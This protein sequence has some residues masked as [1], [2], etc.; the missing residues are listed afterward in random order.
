MAS[1]RILHHFY[2]HFCIDV[3]KG[4]VSSSTFL[5][6][7]R[8]DNQMKT[9]QCHAFGKIISMI[10]NLDQDKLVT[11]RDLL[12]APKFDSLTF[13]S[14]KKIITDVKNFVGC[15]FKK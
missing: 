12:I 7:Y 6:M 8:E 3:T 13:I 1:F 9:I 10:A 14:D 4:G 15:F 2:H 11:T 5:L